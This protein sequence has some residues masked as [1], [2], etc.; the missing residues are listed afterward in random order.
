MT[1][2]NLGQSFA[3]DELAFCPSCARR[4]ALATT[5][6]GFDVCLE[7]GFVLPSGRSNE[8]PATRETTTRA[9]A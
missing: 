1:M 6:T 3:D 4:M 7:C 2:S 5:T 8:R 9:E